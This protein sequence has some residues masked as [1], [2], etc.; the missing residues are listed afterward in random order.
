MMYEIVRHEP[1]NIGER[2]LAFW[3]KTA[4]GGTEECRKP[5]FFLELFF[6]ARGGHRFKSVAFQNKYATR[7]ELI[8]CHT[9]GTP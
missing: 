8:K 4:C 7:M 3:W 6:F 1:V 9:Y 5:H 2:R